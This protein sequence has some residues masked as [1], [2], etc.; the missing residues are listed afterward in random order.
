MVWILTKKCQILAFY[1]NFINNIDDNRL[2]VYHVTNITAQS[3]KFEF[4]HN[5]VK[6]YKET[7]DCYIVMYWS[8]SNGENVD[9]VVTE[10]LKKECITI[11]HAA[12]NTSLSVLSLVQWVVSSLAAFSPNW[13]PIESAVLWPLLGVAPFLHFPSP[14]LSAMHSY[15][16]HTTIVYIFITA[17]CTC[18]TSP[19][20]G[21]LS[22]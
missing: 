5:L 14:F 10:F 19:T 7:G 13:M 8:R 2:F 18:S 3:C 16:I 15:K 21:T 22:Q 11:C 4:I 6:N 17:D 9:I 1:L 20:K 12:W